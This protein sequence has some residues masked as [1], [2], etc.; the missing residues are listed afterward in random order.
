MRFS[1]IKKL[2]LHKFLNFE[3][4]SERNHH[5]RDWSDYAESYCSSTQ[6]SFYQKY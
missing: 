1:F 2:P 5:L 3:K 4:T 6:L